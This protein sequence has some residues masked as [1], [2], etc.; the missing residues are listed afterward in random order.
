MRSKLPRAKAPSVKAPSAKVLTVAAVVGVAVVA[1]AWWAGPGLFTAPGSEARSR[2]VSATVTEPSSCTDSQAHERV[3]FTIDGTDREGKLTACGHDKQEQLRVA[4]PV[5]PGD[6]PITVHSAAATTGY[7][8]LRAPLGLV[9][10][11]LSCAAGGIYAFLV[12]RGP[13][14]RRAAV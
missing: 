10:L 14:Q 11:A 12:V 5:R 3:R 2:V 4:V 1:L 7:A 13:R 6:G 8:A 9:L